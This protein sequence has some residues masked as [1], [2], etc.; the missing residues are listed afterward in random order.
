VHDELVLEVPENQLDEAAA[1]AKNRMESAMEL[2]V[3]L[4]VDTGSGTNWLE[5]H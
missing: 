1:W 3:P 2:D 4:I 5:A